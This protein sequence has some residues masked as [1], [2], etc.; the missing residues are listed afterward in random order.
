MQRRSG[1]STY[2]AELLHARLAAL[3][4]SGLSVDD[5]LRHL[6][7]LRAA[8]PS[9]DIDRA[10]LERMVQLCGGL[11]SAQQKQGEL[12]ELLGKLTAPPFFPAI[13][14]NIV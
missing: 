11:H 12:H 8:A 5:Q 9:E 14:L 3:I 10:L 4:D 7:A 2:P 1:N 6:A 13:F